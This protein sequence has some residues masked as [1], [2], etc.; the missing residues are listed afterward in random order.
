M[1]EDAAEQRILARIAQLRADGVSYR[2]IAE[3]L[4]ADATPSRGAG[5]HAT[6]VRRVVTRAA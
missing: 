1:L 3:A 5:W 6:T 2:R 4:N